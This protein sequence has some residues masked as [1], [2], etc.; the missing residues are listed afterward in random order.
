MTPISNEVSSS[1]QRFSAHGRRRSARLSHKSCSINEGTMEEENL[2][3]KN[4]KQ[5]CSKQVKRISGKLH[6]KPMDCSGDTVKSDGDRRGIYICIIFFS[7]C[8]CLSVCLSL[9]HSH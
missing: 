7:R 3:S 2:D 5:S 1:G 6:A 4:P 9:H 8:F